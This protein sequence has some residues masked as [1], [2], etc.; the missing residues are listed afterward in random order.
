M[1][2]VAQEGVKITNVSVSCNFEQLMFELLSQQ[3]AHSTERHVE[4]V[5]KKVSRT[6]PVHSPGSASQLIMEQFHWLLAYAA[7]GRVLKQIDQ[8]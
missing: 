1:T 5:W 4:A 8:L 3:L 2:N 7:R 6:F